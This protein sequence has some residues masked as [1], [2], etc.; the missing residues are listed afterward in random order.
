M[1]PSAVAEEKNNRQISRLFQSVHS[2]RVVVFFCRT[3]H[4][5]SVCTASRSAK[6]WTDVHYND[7]TRWRTAQCTRA[8]PIGLRTRGQRC[9]FASDVSLIFPVCSVSISSISSIHH[10]AMTNIRVR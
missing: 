5:N 10:P 2:I 8:A 3:V 9:S 7:G 4:K 6:Q 1:H